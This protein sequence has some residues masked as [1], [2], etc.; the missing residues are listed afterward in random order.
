MTRPSARHVLPELTATRTVLSHLDN[1]IM[2]MD[3]AA[4]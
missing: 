2:E 3:E 1:D 4:F